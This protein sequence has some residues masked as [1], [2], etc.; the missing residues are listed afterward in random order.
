MVNITKLSSRFINIRKQDNSNRYFPTETAVTILIFLVCLTTQ[1]SE[2]RLRVLSSVFALYI[3]VG[4]CAMQSCANWRCNKSLLN[5]SQKVCPFYNLKLNPR[6]HM[7]KFLSNP[8]K[9]ITSSKSFSI[10]KI[11]SNHLTVEGF[12]NE[13][14]DEMLHFICVS[15]LIQEYFYCGSSEQQGHIRQTYLFI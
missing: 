13:E 7:S 12:S 9:S 2:A 4:Q 6:G 10:S 3:L 1:R 14:V 5:I 15:C 8:Y 11:K